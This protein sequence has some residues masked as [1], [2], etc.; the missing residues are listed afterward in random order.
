MT[1]GPAAKVHAWLCCVALHLRH[2]PGVLIRTCPACAGERIPIFVRHSHFKLP[3]QV[4]TPVVMVGPG[5]GLAPF[6][7]FLQ[8]RAALQKAGKSSCGVTSHL[9]VCHNLMAHALGTVIQLASQVL[10]KQM[11]VTVECILKL[12]QDMG[13]CRQHESLVTGC[14]SPG[15]WLILQCLS[16]YCSC[17]SGPG[18]C[19]PLLWLQKEVARLHI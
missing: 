5:T 13:F 19:L 18:P 3:K 4:S 2:L 15:C 16:D 1:T 10:Y 12:L 7:G 9:P 14:K 8:E 11:C 6:R 17:R